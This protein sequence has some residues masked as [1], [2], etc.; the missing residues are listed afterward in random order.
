MKAR[1]REINIF[2][3]S[4]LDI[5]C[6][7]LGTFCFLMLV[8][9][10]FYSQDKGAAKAPEVPPGIDPKNYEQALARI[11]Q[12]E[13]TLKQFQDYAAKLEARAKQ[14][15]AQASQ[16]EAEAQDLRQKNNQLRS[17]NPI[18]V[19]AS[20]NEQDGNSIEVAEDDNCPVPQG[21]QRPPLDPAKHGNPFWT[22]DRN[23][24]SGATATYMVRDAPACQYKFFLK[25]LAHN[26][27]LPPMHGYI[28]A[29]TMTEFKVSPVIYNTRQQ[30][31]IPVAVVSVTQDLTQTIQIAI[32]QENTV[33]P[34]SP[35]P[36][37]QQE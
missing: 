7:A 8:L 9:F 26:P 6:G 31:L 10:P 14:S 15:T 37:G 11:K 18:L 4:L 33:P 3:M 16:A 13:D 22:G 36:A 2:N 17:R 21:K 1:N 35:A 12:L 24:F 34:G 5:L 28:A 32:P 20:F 27:S 30:V 25:V 19:L 29:Q 23:I